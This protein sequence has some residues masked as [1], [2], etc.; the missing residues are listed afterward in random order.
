MIQMHLIH[1]S[2][3]IATACVAAGAV[4]SSAAQTMPEEE[5]RTMLTPA[6]VAAGWTLLFDGRSTEHWRGYRQDGFP[7]RGWEIDDGALHVLAGGGGGDILTKEQFTNFE[8][9]LEWRVS[10]DANS[11]IMYRVRE[12][13]TVPWQTGP[14]YQILDDAGHSA[15]ATDRHSTGALYDLYRPTRDKKLNPAGAWNRTRI[16]LKDNVV[17][18]WLN[19]VKVLAADLDSDDWKTRIADSKFRV[20]EN[21]GKFESGH[22]GL[23]DHGNDVWFRNIRIRDLDAPMPN[24]VTLF[25]GTDLGGWTTFFGD[26]RTSDNTFTVRN[27]VLV[28]TGQPIGYLRT[29]DDF[30]N[31]VLKLEW[32]FDPEIGPGNS[33]VL[34]RMIGPDKV[35][36]KSIEAQLHHANA[37]DFWNIDQFDMQVDPERTRGRNTKKTHDAEKPIGEWNEYEIIVDG[38]L[39][40][41]YVNGEKVNEAWE[42]AEVPGKICLQSEGAEIHFRNVRLAPIGSD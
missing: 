39:V 37:G 8:L 32:R 16:R 28:D 30:T 34:L 24:E 12:T 4:A 2:V 5:R 21:F 26:G 14:E 1:V 42:V 18:H 17:T 15:E 7:P 41:V 20:Y 31:Y 40:V 35:W 3:V 6:Q 19:G 9:A 33:G 13:E 36:P 10:P 38:G 25:N 27:G 22:I 11:G 29:I 23:Q